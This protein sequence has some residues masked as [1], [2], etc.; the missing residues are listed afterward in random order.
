MN[1]NQDKS[2][3]ERI[4]DIIEGVP[5]F[6]RFILIMKII[7]FILNLLTNYI[8]FYL[9]NLPIYT[10]YHYQFWRLITTSFITTNLINMLIGFLIWIKDAISLEKSLGTIRYILIFITNSININLIYCFFMFIVEHFSNNKILLR[11]EPL[12]IYKVN[13]SGIWPIIICEMTLLCLNNPDSQIKFLF[14]PCPIR[15]KYYPIFII[16][17][18][19]LINKFRINF[20]ILSGFLY[21]IIYYYIFQNRLHISDEII[22]KLENSFLC[23]CLLGIGGFVSTDSITNYS[24]VSGDVNMMNSYDS[25]QSGFSAFQGKGIQIGSNHDYVAVNEQGQNN[26]LDGINTSENKN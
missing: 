9:S 20:Q 1:N 15:A 6:I 11:N 23:K 8:S 5:F 24:A 22:K 21:G 16:I 12:I 26:T 14:K 3:A 18:L 25:H 4:K 13:N 2:S 17:I 19:S 7:L 10:I